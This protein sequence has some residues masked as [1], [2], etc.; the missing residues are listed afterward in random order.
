MYRFAICASAVSPRCHV[1]AGN[2]F[3][4]FSRVP[5]FLVPL[6]VPSRSCSSA[7]RT[8][9]TGT[10]ASFARSHGWT[11][12]APALSSRWSRRTCR[13][14]RTT[15]FFVVARSPGLRLVARF[16]AIV[17]SESS[18]RNRVIRGK[19]NYSSYLVK[20]ETN[21]WVLWSFKTYCSCLH[22]IYD[23]DEFYCLCLHFIY[24]T[25]NFIIYKVSALFMKL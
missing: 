22:F 1:F 8:R 20:C 7:A 21:V 19:S 4:C 2:S 9:R 15:T 11:R 18:S 24:E 6:G 12:K 14:V 10:R 16:G 23:A 13:H 3:G 25:L 5:R 17:R